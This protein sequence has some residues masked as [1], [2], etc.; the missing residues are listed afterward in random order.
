VEAFASLFRT[1]KQLEEMPVN[2]FME[3]LIPV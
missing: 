3:F 1:V 2:V